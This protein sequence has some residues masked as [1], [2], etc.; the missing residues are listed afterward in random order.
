MK[1]RA[2]AIALVAFIGMVDTFYLSLKRDSGPIPCHV[3]TGCNDVL[4]SRFSELAGIP[5]SWFGLM[6]YVFAFSLAVFEVTGSAQ[7]LRWLFWPALAAFLI[8][9]G[10]VG[11]QA[12]VLERFCE[13]CLVSAA[14]VTTI[15]LISLPVGRWAGRR[16]HGDTGN[17]KSPDFKSET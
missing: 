3:T 7:A 9:L 13:Y 2:L 16:R 17:W 4:T 10:L 1:G 14:L 15:F 8:S 6:F 11:I 5:I 12:F